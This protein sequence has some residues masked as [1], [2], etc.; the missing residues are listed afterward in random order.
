[1]NDEVEENNSRTGM[2]NLR[3]A[4]L[5][6]ADVCL[7]ADDIRCAS[8]WLDTFLKTI[9]DYSLAGKYIAEE[10]ERLVKEK[11]KRAK[12]I[13]KEIK[14]LGYLEQAAVRKDFNT[15]IEKEYLYEMKN[16]C[17]IAFFRYKLY[18]DTTEDED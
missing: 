6:N 13:E 18:Y 11:E 7:T 8:G 1:M 9:D 4:A 15:E 10:N 14:K 3:L 17:W 12:D 5:K 16:V 2:G